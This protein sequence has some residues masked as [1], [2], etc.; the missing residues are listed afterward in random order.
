MSL[1]SDDV[2]VD[3][4]LIVVDN[5]TSTLSCNVDAYPP[6]DASAVVWYKDAAFAGLLIFRFIWWSVLCFRH[7]TVS[8]L[9]VEELY[10]RVVRPPWWFVRP[11][12]RPDRSCYHDISRTAWVVSY[13]EYSLAPTDNLIRFWR[14]KVK[15]TA[16]RPGGESIHVDAAASLSFCSRF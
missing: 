6:V 5:S 9:S 11:F 7:P 15:V 12:V 2:A 1:T 3:Q 8:I 10:F 16:G 14:S 13:K 4:S